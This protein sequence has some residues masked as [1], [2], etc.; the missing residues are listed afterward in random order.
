MIA[1]V[2]VR[3]FHPLSALI[4]IGTAIRTISPIHRNWKDAMFSLSHFANLALC[5]AAIFHNQHLRILNSR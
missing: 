5:A 3:L 2:L 1:H 4:S